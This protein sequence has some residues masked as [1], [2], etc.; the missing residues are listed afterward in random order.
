MKIEI[1]SLLCKEYKNK[2]RLLLE[3]RGFR[4]PS[5]KLIV[6]YSFLGYVLK[7]ERNHAQLQFDIY[8]Y[9]YHKTTGAPIDLK[10]VDKFRKFYGSG[11]NIIM[12]SQES[13][14]AVC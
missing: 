1:A 2:D 12:L 8:L 3:Y 13:T 10:E 9:K 6:D 11:F 14:E 5:L 7:I 4:L